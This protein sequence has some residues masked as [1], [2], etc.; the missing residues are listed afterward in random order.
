[1]PR[2]DALRPLQTSGLGP[3]GFGVA[4]AL[5]ALALVLATGWAINLA[6]GA[7]AGGVTT[8]RVRPFVIWPTACPSVSHPHRSAV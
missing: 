2:S 8:A 6:D 3:L 7:R 1:M 5:A 4:G